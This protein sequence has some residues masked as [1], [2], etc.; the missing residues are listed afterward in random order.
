[1][2]MT[3][4]VRVTRDETRILVR[5]QTGDR[6]VARLPALSG[7]HRWALRA[8]L[9]SLALWSQRR[10]IVVLSADD[11]CDWQSLGLSDAFE[12]ASDSLH[13]DV[14]IVPHERRRRR[15]PHLV[16]LGSFRRERDLQRRVGGTA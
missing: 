14:A 3:A 9:E 7:S 16:G 13:L 11:S 4:C 2:Q 8:L 15:L 10:L 12:F 5:D 1:M 6:L